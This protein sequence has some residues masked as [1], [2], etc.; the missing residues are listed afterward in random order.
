M[1]RYMTKCSENTNEVSQTGNT[2]S[3]INDGTRSHA[4]N[5][6]SVI[7]ILER[8]PNILDNGGLKLQR[9]RRAPLYP[10]LCPSRSHHI[11]RNAYLSPEKG[12][13][14]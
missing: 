13:N 7:R 11:N 9:S 3:S 4:N 1:Y 8:M 14:L 2:N 6:H 10:L 5:E 12:R